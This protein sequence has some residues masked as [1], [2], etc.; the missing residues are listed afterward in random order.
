M[1]EKTNW[2]AGAIKNPGS[3]TASAK[4]AGESISEFCSRTNLSSK[5]KKRC[6]LRETLSKFKK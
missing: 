3:L 6:I 1:S 4:K 2:I 5:N